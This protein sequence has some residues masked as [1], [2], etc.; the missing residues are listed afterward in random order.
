MRL[1]IEINNN[2]LAKKILT[3]FS[4]FQDEGVK[5]EEVLSEVE[6]ENS[7]VGLDIGLKSEKTTEFLKFLY[8][9]YGGKENISS[10]SDEEALE[11]ALRDK[12]GL[13]ACR[14]VV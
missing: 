14:E 4:L 7:K 13:T 1:F 6:A 3:I 10:L 2:K 11:D 12:Y 9:I 8:E 5:V